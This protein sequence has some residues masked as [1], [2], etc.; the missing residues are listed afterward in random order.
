[1]F[2]IYLL[3]NNLTDETY[4]THLNRLK[5][6]EVNPITGGQGLYKKGRNFSI[7]LNIPL[8]FDTKQKLDK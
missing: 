6:R 5:N 1:M 8:S 2:S 7:R 3:A 4:Q